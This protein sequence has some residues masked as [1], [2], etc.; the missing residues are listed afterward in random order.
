MLSV[1]QTKSLMCLSGPHDLFNFSCLI[2]FN[3]SSCENSIFNSS[4]IILT[5]SL[6]CLSLKCIMSSSG[7]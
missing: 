2:E 6:A 5:S 1:N 7:L 4:N 3:I